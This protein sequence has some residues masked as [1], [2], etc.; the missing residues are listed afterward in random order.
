MTLTFVNDAVATRCQHPS[1]DVAEE[2][3]MKRAQD[4]A[5]GMAVW[6]EELWREFEARP[7]WTR[8]E[9]TAMQKLAQETAHAAARPVFWISLALIALACLV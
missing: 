7:T 9:S 3:T 1:M 5:G 4:I 6:D 2:A 8:R